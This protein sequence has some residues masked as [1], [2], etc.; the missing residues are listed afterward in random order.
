MRIW[1]LNFVLKFASAGYILQ[2]QQSD[3]RDNVK[4]K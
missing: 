3:I 1:S 4:V 2:I